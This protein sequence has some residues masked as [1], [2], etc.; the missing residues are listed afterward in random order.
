MRM[1]QEP[2][3]AQETTTMIEELAV[4]WFAGDLITWKVRHRIQ[5]SDQK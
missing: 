5:R 2:T 4:Y 1:I 3:Y